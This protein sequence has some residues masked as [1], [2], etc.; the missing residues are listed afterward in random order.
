MSPTRILLLLCIAEALSMSGFSV[1]PALLPTLQ[2]AWK[3]SAGQAG[4]LGGSYFAGYIAAVSWLSGLTDRV[5]ARNVFVASAVL[6]GVGSLAF[7]SMA[8]GLWSASL[9]QAIAGAGLAGT[10]MPGLRALTD[11]VQSAGQP[12]FIA[13][14]TATFGI[15]A[16]LSYACSGWIANQWGWQAAFA[17]AG[18]E[19]L[20]AGAAVWTLAGSRTPAASTGLSVVRGQWLALKNPQI[21]YYVLG[22]AA[23]CWELFGFRAWI[24]ALLAYSGKQGDLPA[25]ATSL[26]ALVN[27]V[28]I[29][30][31][32]FGNEAASRGDRRRHVFRVMLLSGLL[33]WVSGLAIAHP[34]WLIVILPVYFWTVMADSAALTA[35]L[36]ASTSPPGRG[37][38]MAVYS[39]AGFGGG[40]LA[41]ICVGWILD[42]FGGQQDP[43]AWL[44]A[45]GSLGLWGLLHAFSG[46]HR[47]T[48][49]H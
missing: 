12:R 26:A 3:L 29:P 20:L 32:I 37:A 18:I 41:P 16:S 38:A 24:V 43:L 34:A 48:H 11:R 21:R 47:S 13:F 2:S 1:V 44:F 45:W 9:C 30:A 25:S 4:L 31:S 36:V 23:H 39:L 19:P 14:Y 49:Q 17:V 22:Y 46:Q 8:Q 7:A 5:D 35:G 15:G 6:S 42:R 40:L 28:G 33:A 10:Y 27:L